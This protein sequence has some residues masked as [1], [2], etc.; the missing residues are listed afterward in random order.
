MRDKESIL[1][2]DDEEE[3][4]ESLKAMLKDHYNIFTAERNQTALDIIEDNKTYLDKKT[5]E[6]GQLSSGTPRGHNFGQLP[7]QYI[8]HSVLAAS[9]SPVASTIA[10]T[11]LNGRVRNEIGCDHRV[12]PPK[13]NA[14][15]KSRCKV[16]IPT[17]ASG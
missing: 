17:K 9:Y 11:V 1:I 8:K 4:R 12:K 15:K 14:R 5:K 7:I 10:T 16:G 13:Q 3:F 6:V 2:V